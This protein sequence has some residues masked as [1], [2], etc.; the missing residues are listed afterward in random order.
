MIY[1]NESEEMYL[2]TI[3]SLS[4]E[5]EQVR[6]IDV[7]NKLGYAK[8]SVSN[9]LKDLCKRELII[10][11]DDK[12]IVLTDKGI[13]EANNVNEKYDV[14]Y[15]FIKKIGGSDQTADNDSCKLEHI[16][17]EDLYELIKNYIGE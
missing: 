1:T 12:R 17:S 14:L 16:I 8:S 6:L 4:H 9:A 5:L 15:K 10:Y 3:L 13:K 7:A 11:G 2:K